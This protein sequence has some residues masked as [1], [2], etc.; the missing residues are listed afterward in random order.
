MAEIIEWIER[1]IAPDFPDTSL[2]PEED[3]VPME[4]P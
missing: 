3:G 2:L 4:T 1:H